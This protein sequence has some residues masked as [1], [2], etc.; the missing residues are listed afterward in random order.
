ML[1]LQL[2]GQ[3]VVESQ[4]VSDLQ[5]QSEQRSESGRVVKGDVCE[6]QV[7]PVSGGTFH[8]ATIWEF[9]FVS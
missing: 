4:E 3:G 5:L 2:R 9:S 8:T 6:S 7:A 1:L